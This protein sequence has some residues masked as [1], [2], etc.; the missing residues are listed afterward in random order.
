MLIFVFGISFPQASLFDRLR[1]V[2][3]RCTKGYGR[4]QRR[5]TKGGIIGS[6]RG[7]WGLRRARMRSSKWRCSG[8]LQRAVGRGTL[9]CAVVGLGRGLPTGRDNRKQQILSAAFPRTS[10]KRG[11]TRAEGWNASGGG[12]RLQGPEARRMDS[13][14]EGGIQV[15]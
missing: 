4:T 10:W 6:G 2:F 13:I 14:L 7:F 3:S 15:E 5:M 8:F 1:K 9:H 11:R 12:G